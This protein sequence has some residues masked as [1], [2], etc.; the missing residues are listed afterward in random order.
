[1]I[2]SPREGLRHSYRSIHPHK[3]VRQV[4]VGPSRREAL[5]MQ[6]GRRI[7]VAGCCGAGAAVSGGD[8]FCTSETWGGLHRPSTPFRLCGSHAGKLFSCGSPRDMPP[9][10]VYRVFYL[11]GFLLLSMYSTSHIRESDLKQQVPLVDD[12]QRS[13]SDISKDHQARSKGRRHVASTAM[14]VVEMTAFMVAVVMTTSMA[15]KVTT[16][17]LVVLGQ[18]PLRQCW[19]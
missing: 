18:I 14:V 10:V 4:A 2:L 16:P 12:L 1:M 9:F 11:Y 15:A 5:Q 8:I 3:T 17:S 19:R 7:P 6:Y 13:V